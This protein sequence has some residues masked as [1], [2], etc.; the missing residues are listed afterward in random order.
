MKITL[1]QK[2]IVVALV[3][4]VVGAAISSSLVAPQETVGSMRRIEHGNINYDTAW[5][6][7]EQDRMLSRLRAQQEEETLYGSAPEEEELTEDDIDAAIEYAK[8][9]SVCRRTGMRPDTARFVDC[10]DSYVHGFDYLSRNRR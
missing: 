8:A 2:D 6:L 5:R 9:R 3:A 1:S 4:A 10:L 7:R